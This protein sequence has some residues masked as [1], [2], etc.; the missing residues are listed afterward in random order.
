VYDNGDVYL[1]ADLDIGATPKDENE[2]IKKELLNLDGILPNYENQQ[3]LFVKIPLND[4]INSGEWVRF[5]FEATLG[6]GDGG[7][8]WPVNTILLYNST[9][10]ASTMAYIPVTADK[11]GN[12]NRYYVEFPWAIPEN[13]NNNELWIYLMVGN[14]W[15][16]GAHAPLSKMHSVSLK[17]TKASLL[18]S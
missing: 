10:N 12:R 9:G 11:L 15:K 13:S 1:D 18:G 7:D 6:A 5:E 17:R 4:T 16:D 14:S 2:I 8:I 3:Y